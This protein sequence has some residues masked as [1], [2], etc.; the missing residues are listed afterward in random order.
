MPQHPT[1][2]QLEERVQRL[3]IA[4]RTAA[5]LAD[6]QGLTRASEQLEVIWAD[7]LELASVLSTNRQPRLWSAPEHAARAPDRGVAL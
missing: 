3:A 2:L 5:D 7:A 1:R 6:Y 4:A